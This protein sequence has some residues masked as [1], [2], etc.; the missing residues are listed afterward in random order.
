MTILLQGHNKNSV[1]P[2]YSLVTVFGLWEEVVRPRRDRLHACMQESNLHP[3]RYDARPM[4]HWTTVN[5]LDLKL[6][7]TSQCSII[8]PAI[9]WYMIVRC[10]WVHSKCWVSTHTPTVNDLPRTLIK[11][12]SRDRETQPYKGVRLVAAQKSLHSSLA[13]HKG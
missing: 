12:T 4:Y 3:F 11:A 7:F 5:P 1:G 10:M 6:W 8:H 13:L 2:R 9:D